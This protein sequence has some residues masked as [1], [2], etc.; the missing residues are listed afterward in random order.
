MTC[1]RLGDFIGLWRVDRQI[2]DRRAGGCGHFSGTATF[3]PS[4][5][6]LDYAETGILAL[7]AAPP[8][9]AERR[10]VWSASGGRIHVAFAD[11]RPFH[12]FDPADPAATHFCAPDHY[13]VRYDFSRWPDWSSEWQVSGP[14]K[15]YAMTSRF[16]PDAA[17]QPPTSAGSNG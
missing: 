10:Y 3:T 9:R 16:R 2:E 8:L 12:D 4:G 1:P 14:R 6:G 15:D 13:V 5:A 17:G 7:G 11:G